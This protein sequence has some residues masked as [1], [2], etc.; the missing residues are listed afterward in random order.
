MQFRKWRSYRPSIEVERRSHGQFYSRRNIVRRVF[1]SFD[2]LFFFLF[3]FVSKFGSNCLSEHFKSRLST[4]VKFS[5]ANLPVNLHTEFVNPKSKLS[6]YNVLGDIL[7]YLG[8]IWLS[9]QKFVGIAWKI[10]KPYPRTP[11]TSDVVDH[12][13]RKIDVKRP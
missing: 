7:K 4:R 12:P 2:L 6:I 1:E 11:D 3:C 10:D 9:R 8:I 13:V 5:N